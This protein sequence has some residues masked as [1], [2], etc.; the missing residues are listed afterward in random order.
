MD[1]QWINFEEWQARKE[2]TKQRERELIPEYL[3]A[4]FNL[5]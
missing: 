5:L 1:K 4:M 2:R 3:W